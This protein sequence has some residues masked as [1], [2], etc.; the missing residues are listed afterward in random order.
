MLMTS[1]EAMALMHSLG[2]PPLAATAYV[3]LLQTGAVP[4]SEIRSLAP[5]TPDAVSRAIEYLKL[6]RLIS[7]DIVFGNDILFASNPRNAWKA[8][9]TNFY[10]MRSLHI[11]D[12]EA[13]PP[14][15][16]MAD[17]ERRRL[18]QLLERLC[19]E[20][21]D[22]SAK[23]HDPLRHQHRD[24]QSDQLFS[25]WLASLIASARDRIVAV[26]R[27]P[28]LPDLAP[29][30]VALTRRIRAGVRY[31]RI[32]GIDEVL[33]HGL[34]I[35]SRDM[36]EYNI[37]LRLFRLNSIEDA[38]YIVDGKRLLL[39]NLDGR[40][41]DGRPAHF[42]V[43]TSK[44]PIVRRFKAKFDDVYMPGS[45]PAGPVVSR[46][47]E[48]AGRVRKD[49]ASRHGDREMSAFDKIVGAGKFAA[50]D[51]ATTVAREALLRERAISKNASGHYVMSL[52]DD[53]DAAA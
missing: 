3:R 11:G 10:W 36:T 30:W 44:H 25:S 14:L 4:V 19:G 5:G 37:D 39:K 40:S 15:P 8:H 32:V 17:E 38:F 47:R 16:E 31:T 13:L 34:D 9:D 12:I 21:Y 50:Q 33:E 24:V 46:L 52:P 23:A 45:V 26:E 2:V 48:H 42:G 35:V 1:K 20:I 22:R 41:R 18:Y 28:R 29:I 6:F 7:H 49:L 51:A 53:F 43:Y 27:P